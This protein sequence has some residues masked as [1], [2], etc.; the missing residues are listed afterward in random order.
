MVGWSTSLSRIG[1][2]DAHDEADVDGGN[3]LDFRARRQEESAMTTYNRRH[4]DSDTNHG[5]IGELMLRRFSQSGH[6]A[7]NDQHEDGPDQYEGAWQ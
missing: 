2:E 6:Q 1:E 5:G 4:H 3:R 7:G